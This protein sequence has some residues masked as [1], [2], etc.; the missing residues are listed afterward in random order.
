M[1]GKSQQLQLE[2]A[3][4]LLLDLQLVQLVALWPHCGGAGQLDDTA[5]CCFTVIKG[6]CL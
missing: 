2:P 1:C 4:L 3:Q 5:M 6:Q